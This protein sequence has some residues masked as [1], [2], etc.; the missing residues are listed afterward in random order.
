MTE[1]ARRVAN[2]GDGLAG[3]EE[4]LDQLDRVLI[5]GQVPHRAVTAGI[6]D[7]VKI[8]W[9]DAV[10][11]DCRGKLR[12]R[13]SIGLEPTREVGLEVRLVALRIE[14]RLAALRRGEHA[15]GASVL[16]PV[17]RRGEFLQPEAGLAPCVAELVVGSE[18]HQD[19]H[20]SL[21]H[22]AG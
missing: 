17:I 1:R 12:L 3:S 5:L 11:A 7:G 9:L 16:E 2:E 18:N 4:P 8:L 13:C 21:L 22:L 20:N 19:L 14:R 10:E 6:E 15:L